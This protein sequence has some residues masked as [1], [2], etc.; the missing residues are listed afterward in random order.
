MSHSGRT[1]I[2]TK[3]CPNCG[4]V[5]DAENWTCAECNYPEHEEPAD[6]HD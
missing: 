4:L 5:Q 3:E 6:A 2:R 1:R